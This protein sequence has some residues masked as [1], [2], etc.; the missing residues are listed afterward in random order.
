MSTKVLA[1]FVLPAELG[2]LGA[3]VAGHPFGQL[4]LDRLQRA[5]DVE[6]E[7]VSRSGA[8]VP[9]W[10]AAYQA[11]T[12]HLSADRDRILI[13]DARA[14]LAPDLL[15]NLIARVRQEGACVRVVE[16]ATD[17]DDA[18]AK[19]RTL[20]VAFPASMFAGASGEG[21]LDVD[22]LLRAESGEWTRVEAAALGT[23]EPSSIV[24]SIV[25][26]SAV[27]QRVLRER[28]MTALRAGVRLRDPQSVQIRGDLVCGV[29]VELDVNV[30]IE[31]TVTLEDGVRI[32][33]HSI[34]RQARIGRYTR[35]EPFSLVEAS[36]IGERA[37]IGPYGRIR[38]GS[39]VGDRA[40]IG[41][42]VE[43]KNSGIGVGARINHHSFIGDADVADGVTIGAGT[44]TCNHD[45][46]ANVRTVIDRGAYIGSGCN[47]VAPVRIGEGATV[48]A[49][50]TITRDVPAGKL[51]LARSQQ[52]TIEDWRGPRSRRQ[53]RT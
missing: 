7:V 39:T 27:E 38:P 53:T 13:V 43:V 41:N 20:A 44:I 33:A 23:S 48:G 11:F 30:I 18:G 32:G 6:I 25:E 17:R 9:E 45:G 35:I 21:L 24:E 2:I 50:S 8:P 34:V 4:M 31:G 42:Y 16:S 3:D 15:D 49:G 26:L 28:A 36:S 1:V 40:Q 51:T 12:G 5:S 10:C 19:A 29:G 46:V 14:W 47:L 52:L 22:R 37:V